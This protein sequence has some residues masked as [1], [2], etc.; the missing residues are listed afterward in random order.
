MSN[1][2]AKAGVGLIM[3]GGL[4]E[5]L[6]PES[7]VTHPKQFLN[8]DGKE[9]FL[10]AT[11][12]RV[13]DLFGSGNTYLVIREELKERV[14]S[15]LPGISPKNIIA[16]PMGKDTAACIGLGS[17]WIRKEKGDVPIVVFPADHLIRNE[18]RFKQVILVAVRCAKRGFLVTIGIKSTRPEIGY[19]YLQTGEKLGDING[20]PFFKV[21]R[22]IEKPSQKKTEKFFKE[23]NFLWN[24]G[25][26]AW[27]PSTILNQIKKHLPRVYQGVIRISKALGTKEERKVIREVYLSFPK[28]SI[29]Y[30]VMEKA[31]LVIAVPGDF[32][33][34]DIGNWRA[35]ERIFPQDKHGNII[36]GIVQERDTNNCI[37]INKEDHILGTI[38]LSNLI[39]VNTERGLLIMDK[40]RAQEVK[41]LVK[42]LAADEKLRRYVQ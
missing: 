11:Y 35:L 37:L 2:E 17:I 18:E 23:G 19:G 14:I 33:W 30:G 10:Q 9:S 27:K 42:Q 4:G 7:R 34:D 22:F 8:I 25:I 12:R 16:E 28:V 20:I 36:R 3:A 29:D 24:G 1:K 5:R 38:G 21:E 40:E 26:F 32:F 31:S 13:S 15:Q 41:D 39:I 6:W